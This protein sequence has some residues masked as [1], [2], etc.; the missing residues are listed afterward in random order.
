MN[1]L[2]SALV[3]LVNRDKSKKVGDALDKSN[4]ATTSSIPSYVYKNRVCYNGP[5]IAN[6]NLNKYGGKKTWQH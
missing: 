5:E 2:Y 1:R 6:K 3:E 4:Q